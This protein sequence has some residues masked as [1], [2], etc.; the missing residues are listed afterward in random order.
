M[1]AADGFDDRNKINKCLEYRYII[2]YEPRCFK[3]RPSEA[4][5][6][7]TYGRQVDDLR[8]RHRRHFGSGP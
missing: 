2:S 7:V 8:R 6:S 1:M 4:P 5:L 3:G